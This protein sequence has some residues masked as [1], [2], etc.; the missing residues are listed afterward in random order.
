MA[1]IDPAKKKILI[2]TYQKK[3][4]RKRQA[5]HGNAVTRAAQ[6]LE[7]NDIQGMYAL[8][9]E[10]QPPEVDQNLMDQGLLNQDGSE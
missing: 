2:E 6:C 7:D 9:Q 10:L 5:K 1:N 8:I 3:Q 4:N